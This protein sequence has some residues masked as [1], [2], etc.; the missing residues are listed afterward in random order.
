MNVYIIVF[1]I[2][3]SGLG[4]VHLGSWAL[5]ETVE[6]KGSRGLTEGNATMWITEGCTIKTVGC[7]NEHTQGSPAIAWNLFF[8]V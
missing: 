2:G 6:N 5:T 3:V 8:G 7:M 4:Q 1:I